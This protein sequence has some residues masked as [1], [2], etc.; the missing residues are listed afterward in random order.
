L[1]S[2]QAAQH[3]VAAQAQ[4]DQ[5]RLS[6]QSVERIGEALAAGRG[7]VARDA[8]IAHGRVHARRLQSRLELGGEA[9]VRGHAIA[10]IEAVAEGQHELTGDGLGAG[11]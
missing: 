5:V 7:G 9:L 4:H 6:R 3:V 1:A 11:R 2:V 10:G 8:G